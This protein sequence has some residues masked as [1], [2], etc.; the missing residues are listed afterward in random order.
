MMSATI[1]FDEPEV[2]V[3]EPASAPGPVEIQEVDGDII[4]FEPFEE[5]VAVPALHKHNGMLSN[6]VIW[7]DEA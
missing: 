1:I 3:S 7:G 5:Q 4:I 6:P 2:Q